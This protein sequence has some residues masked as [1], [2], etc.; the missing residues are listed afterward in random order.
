[1]VDL[2]MLLFLSILFASTALLVWACDYLM[3]KR[4]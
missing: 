4:S 1:M 3:E 2:L